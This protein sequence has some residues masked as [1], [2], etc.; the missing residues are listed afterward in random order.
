METKTRAFSRYDVLA[1]RETVRA[2][3]KHFLHCPDC[4]RRVMEVTEKYHDLNHSQMFAI[5]DSYITAKLTDPEIA[6]K[7][8]LLT[9]GMTIG[10][11][12]E[13]YNLP[14]EPSLY[15]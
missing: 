9:D 7:L 10:Q 15:N 5:M 11:V 14:P 13:V 6:A 12:W 2:A 4:P 1:I 3:K 8:P